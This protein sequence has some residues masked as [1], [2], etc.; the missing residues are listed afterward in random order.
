MLGFA[1][2]SETEGFWKTLIVKAGF[3]IQKELKNP[4][5][6]MGWMLGAK[7]CIR[8]DE[9]AAVMIDAALNGWNEDT[10][11]DNAAM[12]AKGRRILGK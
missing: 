12:V 2:N 6:F 10:L 5:D 1:T 4:R 11:Q 7:A 8:V 9:L 3:V